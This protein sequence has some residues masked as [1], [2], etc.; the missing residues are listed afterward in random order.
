MKTSD[1][2]YIIVAGC[3]RSGTT[4]LF[5]IVRLILK[6]SKVEYDSYF[7]NGKTESSKEYQ[8]IKTHT[9]SEGLTAK[10]YKIFVAHRKFEGVHNSILNLSK[11]KVDDQFAN[12]ANVDNINYAWLD[13]ERW[14]RNADYIQNFTDLTD[15]T[16]AL[17]FH[18]CSILNISD[19]SEDDMLSVILEF[20]ALK[21]PTKGFD[22]T[23]LL[24][25][26][27][28]KQQ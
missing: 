15:H 4:A 7:W 18:I 22:K 9:F 26:V 14:I 5:N 19:L 23:T 20:N 6:Y 24:T 1:Q 21:A 27:H 13:S 11:C 10:A 25:E 3:Y 2:K 17:V 16:T 12:A 8:L 28:K